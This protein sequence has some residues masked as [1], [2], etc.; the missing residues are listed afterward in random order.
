MIT[1]TFQL[2]YL[3]LMAWSYFLMSCS[4]SHII[5]K[6]A[7]QAGSST[8]KESTINQDSAVSKGSLISVKVTGLT[9]K[10]VLQNNLGNDLEVS[11]NGS[12]NFSESVKMG[13]SYSVTIKTQPDD[14]TCGLYQNSGSEL[15][16]KPIT[17]VVN[18]SSERLSF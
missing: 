16:S 11:A 4:Q 1:K 2:K 12:F 8:G 6:L 18:S 7:N 10:L 13:E 5:K 15:S 17:V 9:G 3:V 14:V